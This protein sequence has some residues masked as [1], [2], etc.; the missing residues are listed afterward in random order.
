MSEVKC[1]LAESWVDKGW[2]SVWKGKVQTGWTSWWWKFIQKQWMVPESWGPLES[3]QCPCEMGDKQPWI[4]KLRDSIVPRT[5]WE[6]QGI[7]NVICFLPC[8]FKCVFGEG[9]LYNTMCQTVGQNQLVSHE[10]FR[11]TQADLSK[12]NRTDWE[13]SGLSH[14][15]RANAVLWNFCFND[16]CTYFLVW[17][18]PPKFESQCFSEHRLAREGKVD[19][20]R[21][22]LLC[23][24]LQV[25]NTDL[26]PSLPVSR[27]GLGE[28]P[29]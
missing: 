13:M 5:C 15:V 7:T 24:G 18:R 22:P 8:G 1:L 6:R 16:V 14:T 4:D 3:A 23:V 11:W 2:G 9:T 25:K 17:V 26:Y 29:T 27:L 20:D 12:W 21:L 19:L 28:S 10:S